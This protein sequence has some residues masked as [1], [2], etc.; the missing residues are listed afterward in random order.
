MTLGFGYVLA[1]G[2]PPLN[3]LTQPL[4]IPIAHTL[5]AFPF[6][7]RTLLPVMRG[8]NPDWREAASVLGASP[9][10]VWREVELPIIGRAL[11]VAALFAFTVSMGEFGATL[12]IARPEYPT[13]PVVIYR[14]LGQPGALNY[15]QALA[16]STLLMAVCAAA[17]F[18]IERL[19]V[20]EV[21]EF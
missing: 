5:I 14:L 12:L 11:L 4:L 10:H 16:M 15:G 1:L 20:G 19:R 21:G 13:M 9:W 8:L 3:L 18:L 6:V 17:F 2:R 7:V